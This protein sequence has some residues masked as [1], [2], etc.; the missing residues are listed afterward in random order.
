MNP[1]TR[2]R[3]SAGAVLSCLAGALIGAGIVPA[4]AQ[5]FPSRPLRL[6]VPFPPGGVGDTVG[7]TVAQAMSK[8]IGQQVVVENRT[9]A[10]TVIATEQL[11]RAPADG[12]T[13]NI[14]ATSFTVNPAAY[15]KLPYDSQKDFAPLT[16]LVYNPLII[17]V[18][19]SLPAKTVKELVGLA[20]ARPGELTWGVSSA[21]GG[22]R[23]AGELFSET[24]K[25]SMINVAF[26]GGAPAAT[27]VL[28]GH[29]SMLIGNVLDCSPYIASGRMRPIAV[30]SLRR[31][32]ALKS[33]PTIAESGY[34]GFDVTNWFGA[35]ARAGTPKA[36]LDRLHGEL[37]RAMQLPEVIDTFARLGLTPA[38]MSPTEFD[39]FLRMETERSGKIVRA[40][41]L[42][43]E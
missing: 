43:A 1:I 25:I 37:L 10:N 9:G 2:V 34:P 4:S 5:D 6:L 22:G 39:A 28:G 14:I 23:I 29:T 24:A 42:K 27:S 11:V 30:T 13:F 7:R 33:V 3:C 31:S 19:P 17:C 38:T 41:G 15:G 16:R 40:L 32:D 35:V 21:L 8:S 36:A 12:H 20:R 26:G 18:H